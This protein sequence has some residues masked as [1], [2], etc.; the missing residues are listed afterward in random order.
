[1]RCHYCGGESR[2]VDSRPLPEGIRRRRQC[3]ACNRRFTTHER[4]AAPE[5]RV[6]KSIGRA[7]EE[8]QAAKI[9]ACIRRVC[10]GLPVSA[11]CAEEIARK[12]ERE[13]ID[14]SVTSVRSDEIARM[15]MSELRDCSTVALERFAINYAYS[16]IPDSREPQS[17]DAVQITLF[18]EIS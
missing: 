1:M 13:L 10:R 5:I 3:S 14:K 15:L 2:V 16:A 7:A 6:V 17:S 12:I 9:A 8:F 18:G 4:L 11:G